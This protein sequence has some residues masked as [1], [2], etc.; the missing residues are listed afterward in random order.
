MIP[1]TTHSFSLGEKQYIIHNEEELA[2]IV[3]LLA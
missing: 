1:L 3:D 2:L